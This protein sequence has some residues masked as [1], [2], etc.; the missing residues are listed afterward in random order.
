ME[1]L[2]ATAR[3]GLCPVVLFFL[4][5]NDTATT[6]IYTLSLHDALP[7]SR[8]ARRPGR[9][10]GAT[11]RVRPSRRRGPRPARE[12]GRGGR[13]ERRRQRVAPPAPVRAPSRRRPSATR[14]A[15]A[16]DENEGARVR[17]PAGADCAASRG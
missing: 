2:R 16:P 1:P 8:R 13:P 3:G 10:P 15:L 5:F 14:V 4:F 11:P 17:P 6:E 7:I 9:G 12:R